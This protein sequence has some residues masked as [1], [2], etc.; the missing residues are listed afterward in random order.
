MN[1]PEEFLTRMKAQ[2]GGNFES[3]LKTYEKEPERAVRVNTLKI[4]VEDFIKTPPVPLD[5]NVPWEPSGFYTPAG[6]TSGLGKTI[7]HAAGIYYLQEPSA[8]CAVPELDVKAGERVLDLCS[9]PGGK[10]TLR[11]QYRN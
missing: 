10:G 5:G 1:L 11:A 7:A 4:S 9:A 2:L 6:D 3:F 8:M